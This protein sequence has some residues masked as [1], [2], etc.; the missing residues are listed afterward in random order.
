LGVE[1]SNEGETPNLL[2]VPRL[3]PISDFPSD[4]GW[5]RFLKGKEEGIVFFVRELNRKVEEFNHKMEKFSEAFNKIWA[6]DDEIVI[7]GKKEA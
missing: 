5:K 1:Y 3:E 6:R 2:E 4:L 7:M